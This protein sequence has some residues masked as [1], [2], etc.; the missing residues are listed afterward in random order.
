NLN[1]NHEFALKLNE[2]LNLYYPGLSNGIVISDARYNQHLSDHA[3][4]IEFGNQNSEL[5]QVYRSVEHFAEIFTVAIQQELSSA[6][7]TATN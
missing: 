2:F 4:I 5:E 6:S 7:T 3:L 1:Q